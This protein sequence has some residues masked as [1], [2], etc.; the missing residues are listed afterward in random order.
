[1]PNLSHLESGQSSS[2]IGAFDCKRKSIC[3][4]ARFLMRAL[5]CPT[6][7]IQHFERDFKSL[8][9]DMLMAMVSA[10]S[11]ACK[12]MIKILNRPICKAFSSRLK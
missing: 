4:R 7:D 1:M 10:E 12:R 9:Y 8:K 5:T 2:K 11:W 3:I 6:I